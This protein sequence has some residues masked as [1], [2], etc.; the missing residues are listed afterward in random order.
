MY[1]NRISTEELVSNFTKHSPSWNATS[2]SAAQ[3]VT[4]LLRYFVAHYCIHQC[5][6]FANI[7]PHNPPPRVL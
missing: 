7:T 6:P 1:L 5:Q 3:E 2:R 4:R